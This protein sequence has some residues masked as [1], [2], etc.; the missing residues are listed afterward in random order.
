VVGL[1]PRLAVLS[2][3]GGRVM[4]RKKSK[5][6]GPAFLTFNVEYEDGSVTSNRRVSNDLLDQSFGAKLE[7][8]ALNAIL[9]QDNDIAQRSGHRRSK[10]KKI[11]RA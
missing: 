10:I 9:D 7:D 4:A 3:I 11:T 2:A 6:K 1:M 8:L 5:S